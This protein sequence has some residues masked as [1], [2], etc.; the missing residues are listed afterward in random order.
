M[1]QRQRRDVS[2]S[3]PNAGEVGTGKDDE[4]AQHTRKRSPLTLRYPSHCRRPWR[5]AEFR[6]AAE[7]GRFAADVSMGPASIDT[8]GGNG[9]KRAA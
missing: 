9:G 7:R 5:I 2:L 6:K 1:P 8:S 4:V 3:G